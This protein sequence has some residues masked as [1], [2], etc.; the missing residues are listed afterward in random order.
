MQSLHRRLL[1]DRRIRVLSHPGS[2]HGTAD[3]DAGGQQHA[4]TDEY[5]DADAHIASDGDATAD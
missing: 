2:G 3:G 4:A 1:Y 5:A